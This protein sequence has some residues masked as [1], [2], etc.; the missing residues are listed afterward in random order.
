MKLVA[1]QDSLVFGFEGEDLFFAKVGVVV[2]MRR[3][4][5]ESSVHIM[6]YYGEY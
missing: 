3:G 2:M 4:D 6:E 5:G 1:E